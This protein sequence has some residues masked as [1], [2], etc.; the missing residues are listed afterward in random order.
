MLGFIKKL[1]RKGSAGQQVAGSPPLSTIPS[2]NQADS[3]RR[4][5]ERFRLL[6]EAVQEYAIFMLDPEGRINSWNAGAQ[7]IKGYTAEE[8]TGQH[9]SIFYP[10][11]DISSGKPARELEIAISQGKYEE[12]GWRVRKDGSRF[13]A[14]VVLTALRDD[15]G[16]LR[17]FAKVTRDM[18][19]RKEAEENTR[20]LLQEEAARRAAE[21]SALEARRAQREEHRQREQ[22]RVT[23]A[24]IGDA[25]IV[26]DAQGA[27]T[28]LNPVAQELTGWGVEDALGQPLEQVFRIVNEETRQTVENPV[29]KVLREG[30]TVG[31]ANHTVLLA[32]NGREL[33][34]D[35]SGAP[36]RDENGAIAGV[37]LVFRDVTDARRAMDAR[38]RLAAIVDSSD[39]AIISKDL[40]GIILSWNKGAERLFGYTAEEILGQ[41][42]SVLIPP[43]RAEELPGLLEGKPVKQFETERLR[44]D[45]SRVKVLLTVSPIRNV[46]G[47]IIGTSKIA[48]DITARKR[49]EAA[50][51]DSEDRLRSVVNHV[52]DGIIS[53]N[54]QGIVQT[55]NVAAE[56]IFG[57]PAAEVI[58]QNVKML[59]PEPY[60]SDHDGYLHNYLHAGQ[61]KIIGIGREVSGRRKDGS[62]FPMDLAV[63]E[64]SLRNQRYFTGIVRDITDRKRLESDLRQRLEE[65]AEADRRKDE[66]LAMLAH[67]LRNPLAPIRN[68]LQIMK[69]PGA[70]AEIIAEARQITER[71]LHH[72]VRLVDDL[73]DVSRIMQGKIELRKEPVELAAVIAQGVETARPTIDR[74]GQ[75]LILS[76]GPEPLRLE[77]DPIRLAQVIANL[78][79]NAA[80]FSERAGRIWLTAQR[81]GTEAVLSVRDE[82]AGIQPDLLPHVF[83]LFVQGDRSLERTQGGLGIGLTV[84]R[85]LI[86]LHGGTVLARSE[87][88]GKGSEFVV[89]LPCLA[90]VPQKPGQTKAGSIRGLVSRRVLVV[91]DSVDAAKSVAM[92]LRLWKHQV[93]LAYNGPEALKAAQDFQPE[94]I[95]L[96]IGLPEMNGYEVAQQLRQQPQ[97]QK[98]M[99]VAMTGYGQDE[100]QRRSSEAG[101]DQHLIKPVDPAILEGLLASL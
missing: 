36:I 32:C 68:S 88:P 66:F 30:V 71:Q 80:K 10:P 19:A 38:L 27:I 40:K 97:F 44:K 87:G 46:A 48:H 39:D 28:F 14:S 67:E 101:F 8:I 96:D 6:V 51:R 77:A 84:V 62:T 16:N 86:E 22:L 75:Q 2:A 33:P 18:T 93:Q 17:G 69:L 41:S 55:F 90:Q 65:L 59:M 11:E 82:G 64:F 72:M 15:A 43:E 13:W 98:V 26:T 54:E 4:A 76:V 42:F 31:L 73:L 52:I 74:Q 35:D 81:Q 20:R 63:S 29:T 24:S 56:R 61:A 91:D 95:L 83:D 5:E 79:D 49:H 53:I 92:L 7:R 100:D 70:S 21:A 45:G 12:E 58:G 34:V 60:R 25:V 57:Y 99:L 9:F 47:E 94:V 3:K 89:H 85:K 50:L 37:V 1:L 78:L 23:L